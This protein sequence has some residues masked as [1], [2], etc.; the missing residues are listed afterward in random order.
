MVSVMIL[1]WPENAGPRIVTSIV[2]RRSPRRCRAHQVP[3][4]S[5]L[6]LPASWTATPTTSPTASREAARPAAR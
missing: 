1:G 3:G 6:N 2:T 5:A 4:N